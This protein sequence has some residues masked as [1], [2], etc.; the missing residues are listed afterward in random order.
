M[1]YE[2]KVADNLWQSKLFTFSPSLKQTRE[3]MFQKHTA[4][5]YGVDGMPP[6]V[7][8]DPRSSEHNGLE[9]SSG[10]LRLGELDEDDP[11]PMRFILRARDFQVTKNYRF[12]MTVPGV[13]TTMGGTLTAVLYVVLGPLAVYCVWKKCRGESLLEGVAEQNLHD[14][15][16]RRSE[17]HLD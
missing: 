7:S 16:Q 3:I 1:L 11:V 9:Y 15:E 6:G 17:V 5:R 10:Y 12:F 13:I 14:D 2:S 8:L 4:I